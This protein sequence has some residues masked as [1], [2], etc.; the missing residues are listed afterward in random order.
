MAPARAAALVGHPDNPAGLRHPVDA[1][2]T[3]LPDGGLAVDYAI[4]GDIDELRLPTPAEPAP[5]DALWRTTCCEL[6]VAAAGAAAYREFNF[7]SSGQWAAYDFAGYRARAVAQP[8]LPAPAIACRRADDALHLEVA[9][10]AAALPPAGPLRLGISVVL[11]A[12]DGRVGYWALAHAPGRPDFHHPAA[13]ALA[14]DKE[15]A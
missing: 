6:F 9:L 10:P 5:A 11:E 3:R 13:F 4:R 14:I 12:R 2:V 1:T 15:S 8:A 7:S